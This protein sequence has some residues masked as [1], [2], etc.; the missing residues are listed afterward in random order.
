MLERVQNENLHFI[1]PARLR[2]FYLKLTLYRSTFTMGTKE[3][4]LK[5]NSTWRGRN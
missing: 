2:A 4:F 3:T 1:P 5:L